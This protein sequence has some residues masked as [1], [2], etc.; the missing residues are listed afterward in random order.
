MSMDTYIVSFTDCVLCTVNT[1]HF[2]GCLPSC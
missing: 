1:V 2:G